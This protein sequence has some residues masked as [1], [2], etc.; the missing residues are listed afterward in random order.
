MPGTLRVD[1][2]ADHLGVELPEGDYETVAGFLI[3][4]LGRI[5]TRRDTVEHDGWRLR[6]RNMHRRRVVQILIEP[7]TAV[8]GQ[9]LQRSAG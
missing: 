8:A 7:S 1:E 6:V 3:D 5:P 4:R 2:A 9:Q